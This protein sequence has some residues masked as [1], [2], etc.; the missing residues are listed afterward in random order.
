MDNPLDV[1]TN[2]YTDEMLAR[3]CENQSR[4][5]ADCLADGTHESWTPHLT[6]VFVDQNQK[7]SLTMMALHVPFNEADEKALAM[8]NCGIQAGLQA[9]K[10]KTIPVVAIL[11]SE[12]WRAPQGAKVE[13]RCH[14][15]REEAVLCLAVTGDNRRASRFALITR[16]RGCI[17]LDPFQAQ[18]AAA[19]SI[20]NHFWTATARTFLA[21]G[22][23]A[24]PASQ[25]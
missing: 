24:D 20:L 19:K 22:V 3:E 13:P 23:F 17:R 25:P 4:W 7:Q 6:V 10:E 21:R 16:I 1:F 9:L 14:P 15:E 18:E 8:R 5:V 11:S 2:V 12:C